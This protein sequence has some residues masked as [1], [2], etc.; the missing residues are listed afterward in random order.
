MLSFIFLEYQQRRFP[1]KLTCCHLMLGEVVH[2]SQVCQSETVCQARHFSLIENL[3]CRKQNVGEASFATFFL[4][5]LEK[6][7]V[8]L[9]CLLC[10]ILEDLSSL[11]FIL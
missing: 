8:I 6:V 5:I 9:L 7:S 10:N 1:L 2:Y 3:L 4:W 11:V